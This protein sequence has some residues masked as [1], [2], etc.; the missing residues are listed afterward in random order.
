MVELNPQNRLKR[1]PR[2]VGWTVL[3]V[4][5]VIAGAIA[6]KQEFHS[7]QRAGE[8]VA[9][10]D[11]M[12]KDEFERRVHDYLLAHPEVIGEAS[13]RLEAKQREQEAARG[14]AL[15]KSHADQVFHDPADPV[16]GNPSGD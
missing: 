6:L 2:F 10:A 8:A 9:A 11:D 5:F 12:P 3:P 16:G 13:N 14:R 1:L 4:L 7:G 15:L